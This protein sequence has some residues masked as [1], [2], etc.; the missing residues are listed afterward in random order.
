[1]V[2]YQ[3]IELSID[4]LLFSVIIFCIAVLLQPPSRLG[5]GG[6][7]IAFCANQHNMN[8]S[9]NIRVKWKNFLNDF[10]LYWL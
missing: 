7:A 3:L 8:V 5:A 6:I 4:A 10:I 2:L 1:M 9:E